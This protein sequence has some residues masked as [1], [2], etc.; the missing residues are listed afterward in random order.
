MDKAK[1][2]ETVLVIVLGLIVIYWFKKY[3]VLLLSAIFIGMAAL[4][5][6]AVAT[7]IQ[8]FWMKLSGLMGA[9]SGRVI[10]TVIYLLVLLPLAFLAK[11]FGKSSFRLKPGGDTYFKD[12]NHT[13]TKE[14]IMNPW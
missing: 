6:P 7:G 13:Y 14:D 10:L 8:W 2:F 9:V 12:R 1:R 4:L 5:V 3:N 11:L